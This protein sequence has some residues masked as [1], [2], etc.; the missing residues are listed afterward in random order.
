MDYKS[1]ADSTCRSTPSDLA[2]T[3]SQRL[4]ALKLSRM[5]KTTATVTL[6]F[7]ALAL[8]LA[9]ASAARMDASRSLLQSTKADKKATCNVAPNTAIGL[10]GS[11]K[12]CGGAWSDTTAC[13]N[14][15][16]GGIDICC[17]ADAKK[18]GFGTQ[19]DI[20]YKNCVTGAGTLACSKIKG[21]PK[22]MCCTA[23]ACKVA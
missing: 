3:Q 21:Y 23:K 7:F 2:N 17:A 4:R 16:P 8:L 15:F 22:K 6:C 19:S 14:I 12:V 13:K 1:A 20:D 18:M 11:G 10:P 5:A 9:G